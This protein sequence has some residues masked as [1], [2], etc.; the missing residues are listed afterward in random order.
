MTGPVVDLISP[1]G[2]SA[3]PGRAFSFEVGLSDAG[4]GVE[5]AEAELIDPLG[6]V[7]VVTDLVVTTESITGTVEAGLSMGTHIMKVTATDRAG[8]VTVADV[9]IVI[10]SSVLGLSDTYI[11]PNP[12]NP[13]DVEGKVHFQLSR[14]AAVTIKV[15]DFAGDYVTTLP[16]QFYDQPGSYEIAWAGQAA[17]TDLANGAYLIRIEAHDGSATKGATVKAVIWRE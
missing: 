8:N 10:E 13:D 16:R 17:G 14:H 2:G 9:R 7:I 11:Y 4:A 12:F 1:V 15:Y 5:S 3:V 6:E